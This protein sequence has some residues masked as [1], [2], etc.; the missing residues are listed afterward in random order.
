MPRHRKDR[1]TGI[2]KSISYSSSGVAYVRASLV[3]VQLSQTVYDIRNAIAFIIKCKILKKISKD[4]FYYIIY[5]KH[6]FLYEYNKYNNKN[7]EFIC[8]F[9]NFYFLSFMIVNNFKW[10]YVLIVFYF[11]CFDLGIRPEIPS[12]LFVS[13]VLLILYPTKKV[14]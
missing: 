14:S 7:F 9:F 2:H 8:S 5:F 6:M 11:L 13:T 1:V 3:Q 4:F 10:L 12:R